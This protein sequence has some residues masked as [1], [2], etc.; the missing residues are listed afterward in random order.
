MTKLYGQKK[1]QD[2]TTN[3]PWYGVKCVF[4]HHDA[5]SQGDG[6]VYEERIVLVPASSSDVAIRCGE[7]EAREN[8][9]ANEAEYPGFID[10]YWI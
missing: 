10:T 8:A 5:P 6:C 9:K 1:V 4:L 7:S 2:I 3:G